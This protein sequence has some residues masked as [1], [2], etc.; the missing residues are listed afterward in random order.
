MIGNNENRNVAIVHRYFWPQN[1]PYATMLKDVVESFVNKGA[2]VWVY[3][4]S[5]GDSRE[6]AVRIS[7]A[8]ANKVNIKAVLLGGERQSSIIKKAI[9]AVY[10]GCWLLCNLSLGKHDVVIVATT[11]PVIVATLVR[12]VSIL[13]K[14]KV[15]Y[16]CQDIHPEGLFIN[17]AIKSKALYTFLLW[18]D[19]SNIRNAWRVVVLSDEMKKTLMR[20]G[21]NGENIRVINNFIFHEVK[22][23]ESSS[24]DGQ[25]GQKKKIRFVFAGSI[26][27]FQNLELLLEAMASFRNDDR[28]EFV[29]L[30]DGPV[31]AK[32]I[33]YAK[34]NDLTHVFFMPHV[35]IDKALEF[36]TSADVG[37]VSVSP[38]VTKV[39]YPSKSMM[40][41]SV[42]L[43]VLAVVDDFSDL[44][45]FIAQ[46]D[47]GVSV[48][49]KIERIEEGIRLMVNKL[50]KND[51]SAERIAKVAKINFG[52]DIILN[53][54]SDVVVKG[55]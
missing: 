47:L 11:P 30:G 48:P 37:V 41:F 46:N 22:P 2:S 7:W 28:L 13:K 19:T 23:C 45:M 5:T 31:K 16:H 6:S 35:S 27:R 32:L 24:K 49:S 8:K 38:G 18:L 10:F 34:Q 14:F 9:N 54:L 12:F 43:P 3:T 50:Q 20:R 39:A 17:Q 51:F 25:L 26:G 52:K 36:L 4:S 15:V 40:Y 55:N 1:Y 21:I 29:F 42:G 44:S 33:D 53:K